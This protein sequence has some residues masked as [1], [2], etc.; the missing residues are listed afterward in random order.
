MLAVGTYKGNVA[1][2]DV[3]GRSAEPLVTS[4]ASPGKHLDPVWKV[5]WVEAGAPASTLVSV[6]TDGRVT[7]W[8]TAKG[9]EFDDL[10]KLKRT[11]RREAQAG[12]LKAS[13]AARGLKTEAFISRLTAGT[14]ID[15]S[16]HDERVYIAGAAH[17]RGARSVASTCSVSEGGGGGVQAPRTAGSTAARRRTASSI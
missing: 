14:A 6:S 3:K 15:V 9:L 1:V 4:D 10:M 11:A 7:R 5:R 8:D 12:P 2:Y 13:S 17:A 16:A